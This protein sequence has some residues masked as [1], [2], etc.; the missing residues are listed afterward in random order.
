MKTTTF[1]GHHAA[2]FARLLCVLKS[3][4]KSCFR[5]RR[6]R[7]RW[8]ARSRR[9]RRTRRH[10]IH[11][12]FFLV[13]VCYPKLF[14]V[15]V[16]SVSQKTSK[17]KNKTRAKKTKEEQTRDKKKTQKKQD[18]RDHLIRKDLKVLSSEEG[19]AGHL[20]SS[21]SVLKVVISSNDDAQPVVF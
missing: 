12:I 15:V 5:R 6:R 8:R 1:R 7:R 18:Q 3:R 16:T 2:T 21:L 4:V 10:S 19:R 11:I 17:K 9:H 14:S 20:V 13:V